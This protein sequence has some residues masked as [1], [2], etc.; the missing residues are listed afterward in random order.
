MAEKVR[1][2]PA[3][4]CADPEDPA[5]WNVRGIDGLCAFNPGVPSRRIAVQ[6]WE[7]INEHFD[8]GY[9]ASDE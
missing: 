6:A 3:S 7:A 9:G 5:L 4:V 1:T 8:H 2:W